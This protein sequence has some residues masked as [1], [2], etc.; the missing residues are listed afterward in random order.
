MFCPYAV[1]RFTESHT[2]FQYDDDTDNLKAQHTIETNKAK[3]MPCL[4]KDCGAWHD[5]R[6]RYQSTE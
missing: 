3:F 2:E 1:D 5:G 4:E 6:C